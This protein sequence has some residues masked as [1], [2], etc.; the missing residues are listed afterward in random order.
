MEPVSTAATVINAA[1]SL[2]SLF[3][4]GGKQSSVHQGWR[5]S[6][7]LTRDGLTGSTTAWDQLGNTWGGTIERGGYDGGV[8]REFLGNSDAALPIDL[9]ISAAEGFDASLARQLR[10]G[11]SG[12]ADALKVTPSA[13]APILDTPRTPVSLFDLDPTSDTTAAPIINQAKAPPIRGGLFD[14]L[15]KPSPINGT[16]GAEP[17]MPG[18]VTA[19]PPG[20]YG[21][22]RDSMNP[23]V[24][25]MMQSNGT[26]SNTSSGASSQPG[27]MM[28]LGG[29]MPLLLL[30][31]VALLSMKAG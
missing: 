4:G 30:G 13:P 11:L 9:T 17:S 15:L 26:R 16:D 10:E 21:N 2:R 24:P 18:W 23:I 3:G 12:I 7:T 20:Y 27:A 22:Q 19:P 1:N 6:G 29:V 14:W 8:F 31:A 25:P 5:V 28:A